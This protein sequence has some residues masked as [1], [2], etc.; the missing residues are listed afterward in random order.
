MPENIESQAADLIL[1]NSKDGDKFSIRILGITVKLH[2]RPLTTRQII[3]ISRHLA[4]IAD[5]D[6]DK[7]MFPEMI[8]RT[9]DLSHVCKAIA[10]ATGSRIPF[11][12]KII[13]SQADTS[14]LAT[15]MQM[16]RK[17]SNAERFFFTMILAKGMNQMKKIQE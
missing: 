8:N 16:I 14:D 9:C 12:S 3:C 1:G 13:E 15:L 5:I 10:V 11:L 17:Q 2:I 6:P 7:E 4:K